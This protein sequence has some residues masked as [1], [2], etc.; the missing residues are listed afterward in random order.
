MIAI[1]HFHYSER[2]FTSVSGIN[3]AAPVALPA[4]TVCVDDT[5]HR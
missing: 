1:K 2:M 3:S 4:L 5:G